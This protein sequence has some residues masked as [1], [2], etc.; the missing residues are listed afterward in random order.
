MNII[1]I[2]GIIQLIKHRKLKNRLEDYGVIEC[3]MERK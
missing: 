3:T 2:S 1:K